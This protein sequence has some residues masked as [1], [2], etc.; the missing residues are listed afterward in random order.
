M[1]AANTLI[2]GFLATAALT[3]LARRRIYRQWSLS[4]LASG[5]ALALVTGRSFDLVVAVGLFV[6]AYAF[7]SKGAIGGG[8]VWLATFLG[9]ALGLEALTALLAGSV[10]GSIVSLALVAAKRL[11][12]SDPVPLGLYWAIGGLLIV[13]TGAGLWSG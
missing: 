11:K 5:L 3:D 10:A 2:A 6:F 13:L 8:D 9:L 12:M 4:A 7:W 1:L